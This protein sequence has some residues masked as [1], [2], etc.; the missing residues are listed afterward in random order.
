MTQEEAIAAAEDHY[1]RGIYHLQQAAAGGTAV[2]D[3]RDI[4]IATAYFAAGQL[5][6]MIGRS[7]LP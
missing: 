7:E 1:E 5:A 4:A 6:A 3:Q 2:A